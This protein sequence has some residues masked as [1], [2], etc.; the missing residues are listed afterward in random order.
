ML[1]K[2]L[3]SIFAVLAICLLTSSTIKADEVSGSY[4]CLWDLGAGK[5]GWANLCAPGY[6]PLGNPGEQCASYTSQTQCNSDA[7]IVDH[8]APD[9]GTNASGA[10]IYCDGTKTSI[11]TAIGCIPYSDANELVAFFLRWGVGIGGGVAFLLILAG[12]F[13]IM[14]ST[15]NPER[16]KGGQQLLTS[17]IAGL[18]MII[19]SIFILR[20][21]GV[22][23]L[24]IPGFGK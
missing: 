19:F 18:I 11:K 24:Q 17:A 5:C 8:C 21:I 6:H 7:T 12:G 1:K 13:T 16:L 23:I 9:N 2:I 20:L 22:N 10:D 14:T 15:G 4:R 3:F